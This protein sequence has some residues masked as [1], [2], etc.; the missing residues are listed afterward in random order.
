MANLIDSAKLRID[1]LINEAYGKAA[2]TGVLPSGFSLS[3]VVE[4]P[5]DAVNGDYA[6]TH[7]MAAARDM[8]MAPRKI[9]EAITGALNLEGSYFSR[10]EIAGPGFINFF[11]SD[12]WYL[13]V[14]QTIESEGA[15][16]GASDIGKGERV[17]VEFV[18]A[19]PT[20]PMTI[21]NARGGVLGDTLAAAPPT[22][23]SPAPGRTGRRRRGES[24]S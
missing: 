21:G 17:M 24:G 15:N 20:G 2:L 22:R 10:F 14:L 13:D 11:L 7:A 4:I 23:R 19:N 5:R 1:E 6:A 18:S 8:K 16:Y 12:K 9:A 3:G